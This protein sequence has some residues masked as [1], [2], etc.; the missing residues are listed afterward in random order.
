MQH[1]AELLHPDGTQFPPDLTALKLGVALAIGL[2]IGFERQW[3]NKEF[4][5]RTFSLS[6]MLGVLTSFLSPAMQVMGMVGVI[7]LA[8]ML[9]VRDIMESKSVEGTT[10]A[11]LMVTFVLGVLSGQGHVFTAIAGA[12]LTTWL[13]SLKPQFRALTGGVTTEEM[14]SALLLGLFGFIIWP[15]LPN[16][17][18]DP[19][20]L[21]QPRQAWLTVLVVASIGFLNYILLRLYGSKGVTLSAVLG[22]LVNST[23]AVVELATTLPAAGMLRETGVAVTYTTVAMLVR[24]LA[25]LAIFGGNAAAQQAFLPMAGM[26]AVAG[27]YIWLQRRAADDQTGVSLNLD[28]PISVSKVSRFG[29]L[30]LLIQIF[31]TLATRW[32]GSEG[33][34]V[35]SFIGGAVSSASSTAAAANLVAHGDASATQG[36]MAAIVTS[37]VSAAA[38]LPLLYRQTQARPIVRSV[39]IWTAIE[40]GVGIALLLLQVHLQHAGVLQMGKF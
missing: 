12:I 17:F 25:L 15:L 13:L 29:A 18:V 32:L 8:I 20:H 33:L 34:L 7:M 16:H 10:S 38:N 5:V 28:S 14:R 11:A 40:I 27:A 23:A 39:A 9:N 36:A 6:A 37:M 3:S 22:G 2:L 4:G 26:L 31:G 19:W 30:F 35:V 21:L 24:N 1:Y